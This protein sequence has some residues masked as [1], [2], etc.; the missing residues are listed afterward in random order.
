MGHPEHDLLFVA[1]QVAQAAGL[2]YASQSVAHVRSQN[3]AGRQFK[4]IQGS[5]V[6]EAK[7]EKLRKDAVLFTEVEVYQMLLR[8]NAPQS[9]PLRK[10]VTE[11]RDAMTTSP[12]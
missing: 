11:A 2:K 7:P 3:G 4:E 5:C 6:F 9:E 1:T 8:G 10:W 12:K